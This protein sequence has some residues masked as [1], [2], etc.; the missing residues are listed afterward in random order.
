MFALQTVQQFMW[1]I[2]ITV[3]MCTLSIVAVVY[4]LP[5]NILII[6][7]ARSRKQMRNARNHF[8]VSLACSDIIAL[9]ISIPF[10]MMNNGQFLSY[11]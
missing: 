2:P 5:G 3:T 8:I 10:S 7:T 6:L 11:M 1:E 9:L 4:G